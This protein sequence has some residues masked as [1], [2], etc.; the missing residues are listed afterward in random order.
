MRYSL[1]IA[2]VTSRREPKIEWFL[3]SFARQLMAG[4]KANLIVVSAC[5]ECPVSYAYTDFFD[6]VVTTNPKPNIWQGPHRITKQDWWAKSNALNTAIALCQTEYIAFCDDR[7][8]LGNHWMQ[9]IRLAQDSDYAVV[10]SYEKRAGMKVENGIITDFGELLGEDHRQPQ[11]RLIRTKDFYGGSSAMPLE[12]ALGINGFP[13]L[14]DGLGSEDSLFGLTLY[15]AGYD[16][17]YDG[18]MRLIED[19]TPSEITDVMK[20]A[21]K[22]VSPNDKSHS[23]LNK[24]LGAKD[25]LNDY[26]LRELRDKILAGEPWPIPV[27]PTTDWFDGEKIEDMK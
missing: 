15:N 18:R 24:F 23:L 27:G 3:D 12:F 22:G 9:S 19:R 5:A 8:V 7:A 1:T 4:E 10:G 17:C 14:A 26:S 16:L 25:S 21:D 20:R 2:Y 6:K 13:E 11:D